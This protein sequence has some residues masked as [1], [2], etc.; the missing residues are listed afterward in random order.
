MAMD[1]DAAARLDEW[2]QAAVL[3]VRPG[4]SSITAVASHAYVFPGDPARLAWVV[5]HEATDVLDAQAGHQFDGRVVRVTDDAVV[6]RTD[7]TDFEILLS[8]ADPAANPALRA[9]LARRAPAEIR[10][11][12]EAQRA[13]LA[14]GE[15]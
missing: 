2:D 3:V 15:W 8:R 6:F 4:A 14:P 13:A 5:P 9:W 12:R 1:E 10:R 7:V 11:D